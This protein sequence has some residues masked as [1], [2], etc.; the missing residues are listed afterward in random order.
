VRRVEKGLE[1][2]GI[3]IHKP[4]EP[5]PDSAEAQAAQAPSDPAEKSVRDVLEEK[6]ALKAARREVSVVFYTKPG[7]TLCEQASTYLKDK[8]VFVDERNIEESADYASEL[9][10]LSPKGLLPVIKVEE[11]SFI[12]WEPVRVETAIEAAARAH[13]PATAE[14]AP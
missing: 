4:A 6:E 2:Q 10:A 5:S 3:A 8:D 11:Q 12:G 9:A 7:C 1:R 13:L 14:A